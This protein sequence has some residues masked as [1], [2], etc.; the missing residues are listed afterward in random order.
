MTTTIIGG[1]AA[2]LQDSSFTLLRRNDRTGNGTAGH[3]E[4]PYLNVANG[5]LALQQ[6]DAFLPSQGEDFQLVRTYNSR[7]LIA[8]EKDGWAFS[9]TVTLSKN[10]DTLAGSNIKVDSYQVTYGDGSVFDFA[11]DAVRNLWVSTD[12]AGAFETLQ[13]V[14]K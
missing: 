5:N 9:T 13:V 7:G 3:G 14:D 2:G 4:E 11:F 10:N 8:G 1:H 12:G 6:V